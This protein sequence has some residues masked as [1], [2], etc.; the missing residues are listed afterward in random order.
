MLLHRKI[1]LASATFV[2]LSACDSPTS[3]SPPI[4][5]G[6]AL[7]AA[8]VGSSKKPLYLGNGFNDTCIGCISWWALTENP[9]KEDNPIYDWN[10]LQRKCREKNQC[11][12]FDYVNA[13]SPFLAIERI[14]N[15]PAARWADYRK[16]G[17]KAACFYEH[18]Y[19]TGKE[20]CYDSPVSTTLPE[21]IAGKVSSFKLVNTKTVTVKFTSGNSVTLDGDGYN[22]IEEHNDSIENVRF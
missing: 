18:P 14:V 12:F 15:G 11:Q 22:L 6:S 10:A 2:M 1:L 21:G 17:K 4:N 16:S 20:V 3:T 13:W 19:F 9:N 5:E 7:N 8:N